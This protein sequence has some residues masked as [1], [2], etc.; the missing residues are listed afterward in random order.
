[1]EP[2]YKPVIVMSG[3]SPIVQEMYLVQR[4]QQ[5]RAVERERVEAIG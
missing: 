5:D 1:M 4:L 2:V 3:A